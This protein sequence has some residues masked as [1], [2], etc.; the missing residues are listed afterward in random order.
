MTISL[1]NLST[2]VLIILLPERQIQQL[3]HTTACGVG[4]GD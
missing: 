1:I 3:D 4:G 2:T